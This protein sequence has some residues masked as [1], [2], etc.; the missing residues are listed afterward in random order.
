MKTITWHDRQGDLEVLTLPYQHLCLHDLST[1]EAVLLI[2]ASRRDALHEFFLGVLCVP[3][4][5]SSFPHT[6][7]AWLF[8][9]SI[10]SLHAYHTI[11]ADGHHPG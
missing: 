7:L 6:T 2:C 1:L 4:L 10:L 5:P 9:N 8:L 11:R 3:R